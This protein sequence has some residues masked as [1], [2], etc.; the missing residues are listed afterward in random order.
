[1]VQ[2][3]LLLLVCIIICSP[4]AEAF[5]PK[6]AGIRQENIAPTLL[7]SSDIK[8]SYDDAPPRTR[9]SYEPA[10]WK[11][12]MSSPDAA[13]PFS[14]PSAENLPIE[15]L[16]PET[17]V[18]PGATVSNEWELDVYSRP[19]TGADG[20]KL[21]ELLI[22][23]ATGS[24]RH[25]SPIPS[26]MVNSREVRKAIEGVIETAPGGSKPT[27]IRFFRNAM[28]NMIDIALREVDVAVK[29][30]RTTYAMYQWLEE[31]ERDVYPNMLGY[32]ANMKQPGFF[33]IRVRNEGVRKTYS[34]GRSCI[35][36][37][38]VRCTWHEC[39]SMQHKLYI[40]R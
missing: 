11:L 21:W 19:V 17:T 4:P 6:L 37:R 33:D 15:P 34:L 26:N 10:A 28:F 30:C 1:M 14:P 27:V 24:L 38:N 36:T 3:S 35:F 40:P 13:A 32:K 12:A 9:K 16:R 2:S 23:D 7:L 18:A 22:C 29:P 20:K 25:V 5:T 8:P 39:S 31:R